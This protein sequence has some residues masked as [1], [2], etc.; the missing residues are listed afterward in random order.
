MQ[1]KKSELE[2]EIIQVSSYLFARK[3][4]KNTSIRDIAKAVHTTPSNI[5]NY[6]ENKEA[7]LDQ[8]VKQ[9]AVKLEEFIE[10]RYRYFVEE[11]NE[12]HIYEQLEKMVAEDKSIQEILGVNM[13]ILLEKCSGTKYE[14]Y[15]ESMLQIMNDY[16]EE[17]Y[18]C[19]E[20]KFLAQ[21]MNYLF[22][23]TL[24][25]AA[26]NKVKRLE[27]D[28]MLEETHD[29]KSRQA[30]YKIEVDTE[31]K[32]VIITLS[33]GTFKGSTE[34]ME[35]YI[36]EYTRKVS[37]LDLTDY[38]LIFDNTKAQS[39]CQ[40][41]DE[42]KFAQFVKDGDYKKVIHIFNKDQIVMAMRIE[43]IS[44]ELDMT[45]FEIIIKNTRGNVLDTNKF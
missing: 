5:Y 36:K 29:N 38:K 2:Q 40:F 31:K 18:A 30:L 19:K 9:T 35:A 33:K 39:T 27:K 41:K 4:V 6:Y 11:V 44:K 23:Q 14:Q 32:V 1:Y 12:K 34:Q 20:K 26:R 21:N 43:K 22:I 13:I 3:G 15:K 24:L 28:I 7:I 25:E 37:V 16:I 17:Y 8:V 45:N 42:K 10:T